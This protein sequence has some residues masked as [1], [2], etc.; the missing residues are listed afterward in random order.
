[1]RVI[2]GGYSEHHHPELDCLLDVTYIT[3]TLEPIIMG[4]HEC[5]EQIWQTWVVIGGEV[6]CNRR[7]LDCPINIPWFL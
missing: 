2:I 4:Y 1:M 3:Q 7:A 6:E 5:V